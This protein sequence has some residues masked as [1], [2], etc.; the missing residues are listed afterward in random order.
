MLGF[1]IIHKLS[2]YSFKIGYKK[3]V[4]LVLADF[5]SRAPRD[6]DAEMDQVIPISYSLFTEQVFDKYKNSLNP[7]QPIERRI[8]R[9]YAKKMG[10]SVPDLYPNA[11]QNKHKCE[12]AHAPTTRPPQ[13]V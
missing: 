5:L 11:S 13:I 6:G 4:E 1:R 12:Q 3:G 7:V 10:I 9:G 2:E 8:T